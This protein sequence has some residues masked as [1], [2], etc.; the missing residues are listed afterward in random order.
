VVLSSAKTDCQRALSVT[1]SK[2][3]VWTISKTPMPPKRARA[4]TPRTPPQGRRRKATGAG[5]GRQTALATPQASPRCA[6]HSATTAHKLIPSLL[7]SQAAQA[8]LGQG[9]DAQ[10]RRE[11][12]ADP[13]RRRPARAQDSPLWHAEWRRRGLRQ[14]RPRDRHEAA[15]RPQ[16]RP[17]PTRLPRWQG[18][19][20][21]S[22]HGAQ[23][24]DELPRRRPAALEARAGRRGLE[25]RSVAQLSRACH[26]PQHAHTHD[27][28]VCL[29]PPA[30]APSS[31]AS[32]S[33][34]TSWT[35]TSTV[36]PAR[37]RRGPSSFERRSGSTGAAA[38]AAGAARAARAVVSGR[39]CSVRERCIDLLG[40]IGRVACR[41]RARTSVERRNGSLQILVNE[42]CS[43]HPVLV[44]SRPAHT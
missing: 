21:L 40:R 8:A 43:L 9:Q 22:G 17:G 2:T 23:N 37:A 33:T 10:N 14:L 3:I 5:S 6:P 12:P 42:H 44:E 27:T 19:Q 36:P 7:C 4:A 41:P 15:R 32:R 13:H 26:Q 18:R 35:S 11:G 30:G 39:T 28:A 1:I 38:G 16:G 29:P 31:T 24:R 20:A 25:V 34:S